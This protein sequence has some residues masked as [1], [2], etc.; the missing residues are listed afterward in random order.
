MY[1]GY[2]KAVD[3]HP[4]KNLTTTDFLLLNLQGDVE[5]LVEA[6]KANKTDYNEKDYLPLIAKGVGH[7]SA[8]IKVLPDGSDIFVSQ[9]TWNT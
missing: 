9:V 2:S 4:E 5:D 6:L 7:C 3:G 1:E 8:L